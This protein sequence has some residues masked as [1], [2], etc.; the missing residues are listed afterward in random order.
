MRYY[1]NQI[2]NQRQKGSE[3]KRTLTRDNSNK[4][5]KSYF[6]YI[7]SKK[8]R[9]FWHDDSEQRC[10]TFPKPQVQ[11]SSRLLF[12]QLDCDAIQ[13]VFDATAE[14]NDEIAPMTPNNLQP[15]HQLQILIK[16]LFRCRVCCKNVLDKKTI[17]N[18]LPTVKC[19]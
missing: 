2:I 7:H 11:Y 4:Y 16:T 12:A 1:S 3:R 17:L 15:T 6:L 10:R 14:H 19:V 8:K 5:E 18:Q 13:T 9:R